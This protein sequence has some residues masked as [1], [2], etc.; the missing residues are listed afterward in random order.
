MFAVITGIVC[1]IGG[2][3]IGFSVA[4]I[5][6]LLHWFYYKKRREINFTTSAEVPPN[7]NAVE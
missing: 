4:S 1:F 3:V 6:Y 7:N 5:S 2:I